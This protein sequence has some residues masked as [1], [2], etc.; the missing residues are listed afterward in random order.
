M[1][2]DFVTQ[3]SSTSMIWTGE[4]PSAKRQKTLLD[5]QLLSSTPEKVCT[6]AVTNFIATVMQPFIIG[7]YKSF[8]KTTK[9]LNPR[10]IL[11]GTKYFSKYSV[12]K[13]IYWSKKEKKKNDICLAKD[14]NGSITIDWWTSISSVLF[15][16]VIAQYIDNNWKL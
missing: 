6:A 12:P 8:V 2:S 13:K 14:N 9:T 3:S 7:E 4:T 15:I 1:N 5:F 16:A 11:P 10:Y